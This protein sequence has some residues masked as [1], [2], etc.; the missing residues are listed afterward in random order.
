MI[1]KTLSGLVKDLHNYEVTL[2]AMLEDDD[3]SQEDMKMPI[4]NVTAMLSTIATECVV[5]ACVLMREDKPDF[6]IGR[7]QEISA[8]SLTKRMG[9]IEAF[10]KALKNGVN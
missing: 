2:T 9:D 1:S 3:F 5:M 8:I 10:V 7:L 6:I 4:V